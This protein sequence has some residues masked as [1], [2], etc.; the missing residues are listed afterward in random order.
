MVMALE[1]RRLSDDL[2][3]RFKCVRQE[4]DRAFIREDK[5]VYLSWRDDFGWGAWEGSTL[6][7]RPWDVPLSQ[8]IK[9]APPEGLW[10]SQKGVKSY[11]YNLVHMNRPKTGEV[12]V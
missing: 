5:N 7:G 6:H 3:Y 10:V 4:K 8:Q 11:C 9:D 1:L 12:H 2:V